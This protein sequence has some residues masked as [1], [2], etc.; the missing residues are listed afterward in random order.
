MH[1]LRGQTESSLKTLSKQTFWNGE[2]RKGTEFISLNNFYLYFHCASLLYWITIE[3]LVCVT[4]SLLIKSKSVNSRPL[5]YSKSVTGWFALTAIAK[6]SGH[7]DGVFP[8]FQGRVISG[9]L[10]VKGVSVFLISEHVQKVRHLG[11]SSRFGPCQKCLVQLWR[12]LLVSGEI[13][14]QWVLLCVLDYFNKTVKILLQLHSEIL[15][16]RNICGREE[17]SDEPC[18]HCMWSTPNGFQWATCSHQSEG[19]CPIAPKQCLKGELCKCEDTLT[20]YSKYC[21]IL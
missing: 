14:I 8:C 17:W 4:G 7:T 10:S 5:G 2:W 18:V 16:W 6:H 1:H 20:D 19:T 15:R 12:L 3:T 21:S 13:R 11:D 9:R